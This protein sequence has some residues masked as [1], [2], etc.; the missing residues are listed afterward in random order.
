MIIAHLPAGYLLTKILSLK[1][2]PARR[3][4]LWICGL[5]ASLLPDIDIL[6]FYLE[7]GVRNHRYYATHW[8]LFWMLMFAAA[9]LILSLVKKHRSPKPGPGATPAPSPTG[10]PWS[11]LLAYPL[12]MLANVQLHLLLDCLAAPIFYAAPFSWER[13]HLIQVP[14]VYDWWVWNF[15]RHWT[16]QLELMVWSAAALVFGLSRWEGQDRRDKRGLKAGA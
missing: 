15:L 8:P 14:A 12:V 10:A 9:V 1:F 7:G 11:G 2:D 13:I 4:S 16:F 3:T 5:A 6:W